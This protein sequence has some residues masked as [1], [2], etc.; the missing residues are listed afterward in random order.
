[1]S[2][3]NEMLQNDPDFIL[4]K[5]FGMSLRQCEERYPDGA[6][7]H[8][9]AGALGLPEDRVQDIYDSIVKK[10]RKIMGVTE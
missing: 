3:D 2:K 9:V 4:L 6:P 5:R 7:N 8:I 1:M 10:L